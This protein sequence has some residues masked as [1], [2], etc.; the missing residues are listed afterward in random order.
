LLLAAS[1]VTSL[2]L[3]VH[4][5]YPTQELF[6]QSTTEP[7][8]QRQPPPSVREMPEVFRPE[9]ILIRTDAGD[10]AQVHAGST[11][12]APLWRLIRETITG[13][14]V[15]GGAYLVD[16]LPEQAAIA[17]Q[18]QLHLPIALMVS[19]WADL[20]NWD[21]P[22][23]RNGAIWVDRL[24][25]ALGDPGAVYLSGPLGYHLYLA[26]LRPEQG[27]ALRNQLQRLDPGLFQAFRALDLAD[28][29][30][31]A[32]PDVQVPV[33]DLVPPAQVAV[34]LP[35]QR[36]EEARYFPDL[37]VVRQIDERDARSLTDGLRLLRITRTG[38][39]Q[40]RTADAA[41]A[42]AT[43]EM[44]RA[45]ELAQQWVG[46]RGGWPQDLVLRRY[47]HEPGRGRL[48]FAVQ[49][50]GPYPVESLPGAVQVHVSAA[51]RVVYFEKAP[52]VVNVTFNGQPQPVIAPEEALRQALVDEPSL[53][54]EP[55][56]AM[57]LAYM[58]HVF[59]AGSGQWVA[60][61][62]WVVQVADRRV[63][64]PAVARPPVRVPEVRN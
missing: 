40:Y 45:L 63:Y 50:G 9:R 4:V 18:I 3:S 23:L 58:L 61:P 26:D 57:Y 32:L 56:R 43:P 47:V 54:T 19:Q 59:P 38:I 25:I 60:E 11:A 51:Q 42:S 16:A 37:S 20:W 2:A 35:E 64:V 17:P 33:V 46:S 13:L 44:E 27:P 34:A 14:E 1:V 49:T 52:T 15:S 41:A 30:L 39:L 48:E 8:L 29:G 24:T 6:G 21:A 36:D 12:Y 55:I 7:S 31:T 5:W 10:Q 62:T 28:L 22:V 53:T